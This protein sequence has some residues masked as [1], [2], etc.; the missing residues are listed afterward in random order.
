MV[1][2]YLRRADMIVMASLLS[3]RVKIDDRNGGFVLISDMS[4]AFRPLAL[5]E[6]DDFFVWLNRPHLRRF[7]QKRPIS[8]AEIEA[9]YG[10]RIR[11]DSP[12]RCH[13]ALN[14]DLPFGYLQCYRLSDHPDWA[15]LIESHD[16]IGVDLAILEPSMLGRG[17]GRTMLGRYLRDI[18]FPLF[19]DERRCFIVHETENFSGIACSRAVGF[20]IVDSFLEEGFPSVLL[21]LDRDK[22]AVSRG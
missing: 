1:R 2:R 5:S 7:F 21:V 15:S 10:P 16:G 20:E 22:W 14:G 11:D 18:A 13:L 19:P 12:T 9:K 3:A 4:I 8:R 6:F 17:L